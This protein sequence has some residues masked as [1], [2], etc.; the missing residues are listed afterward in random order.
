[1]VVLKFSFGTLVR[2]FDDFLLVAKN[3]IKIKKNN[4]L[5]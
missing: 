3:K 1:M 2:Q 4:Y 5:H